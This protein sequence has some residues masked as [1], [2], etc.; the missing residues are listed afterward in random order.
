M[1]WLCRYSLPIQPWRPLV[2]PSR[3]D[4]VVGRGLCAALVSRLTRLDLCH[5]RYITLQC[6]R[7]LH[8]FVGVVGFGSLSRRLGSSTG[9]SNEG[10]VIV[11]I[12]RLAVGKDLF[13]RSLVCWRVGRPAALC[14]PS[15]CFQSLAFIINSLMSSCRIDSV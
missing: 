14:A 1:T 15:Q 10:T 5:R 6:F 3:T 8:G 7:S 4:T 2:V 12:W 11:R 9:R 13:R